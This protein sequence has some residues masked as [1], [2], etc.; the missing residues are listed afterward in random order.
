MADEDALGLGFAGHFFHV[1]DDQHVERGFIF[2]K[3]QPKLLFE[4]GRRCSGP[5]RRQSDHRD[6]LGGGRELPQGRKI[7][8]L[9]VK[10][11]LEPFRQQ[12]LQ[13]QIHLFRGRAR[14]HLCGDI[15]WFLRKPAR[16]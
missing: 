9:A 1:I 14:R 12:T 4:S 11:Q 13:H 3:L 8:L 16:T 6:W 10:N 2:L 5:R 7:L 15:V